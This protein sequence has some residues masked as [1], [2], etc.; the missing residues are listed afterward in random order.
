MSR[1]KYPIFRE[2]GLA[3]NE[4]PGDAFR[5]N[6]LRKI[7]DKAKAPLPELLQRVAG[8]RKCMRR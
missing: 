2:A 8:S 3:I 4:S 1:N 7:N 6:G 5:F